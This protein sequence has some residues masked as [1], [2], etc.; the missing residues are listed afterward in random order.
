[1]VAAIAREL[2]PVQIPEPHTSPDERGFQLV[3]MSTWL[4]MNP[5]DWHP[6]DATAAIDGVSATVTATPTTMTWDMGDGT[7]PV[8][9][10]GPGN[11]YESGGAPQCSHVYIDSSHYAI[12]VTVKWEVTWTSNTGAAGRQADLALSTTVPLDVRQAQA[13]TN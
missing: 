7:D 8:R 10:K 13:V 12:R 5:G 3:G 1:V 11:R 6:V 2:L 9:C 4:Y